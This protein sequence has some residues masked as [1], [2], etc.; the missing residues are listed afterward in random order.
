MQLRRRRVRPDVF[1][2]IELAGAP[3]PFRGLL[4]TRSE[5]ALRRRRGTVQL[6]SAYLPPLEQTGAPSPFRLQLAARAES[7]LR[8]RRG[9]VQ[10]A[11][12]YFPPLEQARAPS[13]FRLLLAAR[14][15][16]GLRRRRGSVRLGSAYLP[17]LE[18]LG[19]RSPF[20]SLLTARSES[21]LRQ[22]RGSGRLRSGLA[23]PPVILTWRPAVGRRPWR[24]GRVLVARQHLPET[25]ITRTW[26]SVRD[27]TP[28]R[29]RRRPGWI[30]QAPPIPLADAQ[31]VWYHIYANT[32]AGDP[33]N[34]ASPIATVDGLSWI[35]SRLSFP[36]TWKFGVRA[37]YQPNG[38]EERN[39]DC[40]I[41]LILDSSGNDITNRPVPP[42][43]LRAMA[44]KGGNLKVEWSHPLSGLGARPTTPV[45][46]NVYLGT[47]TPLSYISPAATVSWT[48]SIMNV[49]TA[50]LSG[51]TSG[52]TYWIG[53]RSYNAT[54][55]EPNTATVS[56]ASDATGPG[57]VQSL[58][59]SAV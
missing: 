26:L 31:A 15:E 36:G 28:G 24:G 53:V 20:R 47:S 42:T 52:T 10:L 18:Q 54:S 4:A 7:G 17:A 23:L 16:S 43:G 35:S 59:A 3:G 38:L 39:L 29:F 57:A 27:V 8:R 46:F 45:G 11:S 22:R 34:Y 30:W 19:V 1:P 40:S 14:A 48:S 51:L 2:P 13:P 9:S 55:E 25:R 44:V 58:T 33:I 5:S 21:G 6:G 12:V 49:F 50:T 41:T 56:C 32:G 37:F